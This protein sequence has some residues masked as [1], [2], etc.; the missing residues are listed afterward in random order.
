MKAENPIEARR[1][2]LLTVP[3]LSRPVIAK[4]FAGG[5]SPRAA[6]KAKCFGLHAL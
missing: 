2:F 6:I 4:A 5:G 3:V 1:Q